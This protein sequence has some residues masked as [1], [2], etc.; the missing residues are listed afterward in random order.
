MN[1]IEQKIIAGLDATTTALPNSY[2]H[3]FDK[4]VC[5][6]ALQKSLRRGYLDTA[7]LMARAFLDND[8]AYF[9]RRINVIMLED[10]GITTV[11][12]NMV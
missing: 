5:S 3:R 11:R 9:W 6:S 10:V 1:E 4:W 7:L 12:F 8:P 2:P